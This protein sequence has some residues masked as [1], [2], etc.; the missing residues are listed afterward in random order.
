[1]QSQEE[2]AHE[3]EKV[4][5]DIDKEILAA[6][7]VGEATEPEKTENDNLPLKTTKTWEYISFHLLAS[8]EMKLC[9]YVLGE[10]TMQTLSSRRRGDCG[11]S[12]ADNSGYGI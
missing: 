10:D 11:L 4:M 7:F 6:D 8:V 1:M 12:Y 9:Q 5:S 2:D 3:R